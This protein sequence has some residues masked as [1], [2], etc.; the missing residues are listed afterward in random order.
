V[1]GLRELVDAARGDLAAAGIAGARAEAELLAA[2]ALGLGR[3]ELVAAALRGADVDGATAAALTDLVARRCSRVP[4]QHLTGRAPFRGLDLAVGPGVFVPRPE[5]EVVA[6]IAVAEAA[7]VAATGAEPLVADLC[8]GSAA[9]ALAVATEVPEARVLA[10]EVDPDALA[11]ARRNVEELGPAGRVDLRLGDVIGCA[12]R[13]AVDWVGHADVVVANPPYIPPDA[14]PRDAEVRDH[15]PAIALYGGGEDGLAVPAAVVAAA[16]ELL[17][18]CGLLV[19]EHAEDQGPATRRL[20]GGDGWA[21]AGT[22]RDLTGRPRAL[23]ARRAGA[24]DQGAIPGDRPR[25]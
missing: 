16:A 2:H 14:V 13:V 10:V 20:A 21:E 24:D 3:G 22:A 1:T 6:G 15:D 12:T 9:I 7:R 18:P 11:W 19:M 25:G 8:A 23:V 17:R 5:T 4:L